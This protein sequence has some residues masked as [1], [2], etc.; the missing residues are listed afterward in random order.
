[1]HLMVSLVAAGLGF[2]ILPASVRNLQRPDVVYRPLEPQPPKV[3]VAAAWRP[4]EPSPVLRAFLGVMREVV[5]DH[6]PA[7]R[8]SAPENAPIP[9]I[10]N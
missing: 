6:T 8:P 1:M 7:G 9:P 10:T 5:G 4:D 2:A 3:V